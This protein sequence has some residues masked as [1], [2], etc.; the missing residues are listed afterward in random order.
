MR[1]L[2]GIL[3]AVVLT[4]ATAGSAQVSTTSSSGVNLAPEPRSLLLLGGGL[5]A[6]AASVRRR[7]RRAARNQ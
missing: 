6:L 1:K 2:A 3:V 5:I 4:F 7:R